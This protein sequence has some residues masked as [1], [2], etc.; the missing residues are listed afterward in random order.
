MSY[1]YGYR[2]WIKVLPK[3]H[4]K[5]EPLWM[6]PCEVLRHDSMG[7]YEV[8][9]PNGKEILNSDSFKPYSEQIDGDAIPVHYYCPKA[10]TEKQKT[11]VV[12]KIR[13]H[14][15]VNGKLKWLVKWKNTENPTWEPA[16][17]F[18]GDVQSD[19]AKY[20]FEKN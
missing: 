3:D 15:T 2:V 11:Y 16:E 17:S 19:W 9:T 8:S 6:G 7:R 18:I 10:I 13:K 12:D 1:K 20:C 4:S 14:K 5:L